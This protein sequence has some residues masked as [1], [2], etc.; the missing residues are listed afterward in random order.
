MNYK[1]ISFFLG[2]YSLF[3][4]FFSF[5]NILY[6][7]YFN[8]VLD[9]D[10]YI[11]TL[12]ISLIIGCTFCL[13]GKNNSKNITISDQ[14]I[15]IVLSYI[16]LP[17]LISIPYYLSLYNISFI[18][19]YFESISGFTTTGFSIIDNIHE[20]DEP[21][22]L[23]RSSSQWLGGL[24]FLISTIGTLGAK[25]I[26]IKPNYL[27][28][29]SILGG[30]FYNNF[31]YNFLRVLL[32]YTL[33]TLFAF[34]IYTLSDIRILDS[35]HLAFTT[36]ST[37][38]FLPKDNLSAIVHNNA[39]ILILSL[40]FL[41]PIFN[42]YLLFKIFTNQF[43]LIDHQ[44]DFHLGLIIIILTLFL[45][46]FIIQD[47]GL[48]LVLFAITSSISTSGISLYS[49]NFDISL[50]LILLTIIGG[51][52]IS[53]S[54][55]IKYIRFY[56]LLKISY[57]EIYRL[58]KPKNIFNQNLFRTDS[59]I[60]DVESKI[61]FLVFISF[62]ISVF[63]L[64]SIL[65]LEN[66]VF[67]DSF[68]LAILAITNTVSSSLYGLDNISFYDLNSFTKVSLIAFMIFGKIEIITVLFLIKKFIFR[69]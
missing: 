21:L 51:S 69:E 42:F 64:S 59:K 2:I 26:R 28:S 25:Q 14:I 66:L 5:L 65:T 61:A 40:V 37:G 47:E 3:I 27:L 22:L 44:E 50:F 10:S 20:I 63:L 58:V 68:K 1:G 18:N 12:V 38:G 31:N 16:F 48:P 67:E 43:R 32:I 6:S 55:G 13:L 33:T 15:L 17:I 11:V 41:F 56:I 49:S 35:L 23:W 62:V 8:F 30:N 34:F 9:L 7:N 19:S 54:S 53:T 36:I 29:D 39:Q 46:F 60:G 4:S 45:Y 57:K 24:L 52:I